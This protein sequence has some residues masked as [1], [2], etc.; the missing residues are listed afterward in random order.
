[1]NFLHALLSIRRKTAAGASRMQ[2]QNSELDEA[3]LVQ[4]ARRAQEAA[5][6]E[7]WRAHAEKVFGTAHRITRNREDAEGALQG[8]FL[9]AFLHIKDFDGR[10]SF[11][12]GSRTRFAAPAAVAVLS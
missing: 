8:S 7:L 9:S 4:N 12:R 5:F 11:V 3:A 1:M 6:D 10:S 2:S